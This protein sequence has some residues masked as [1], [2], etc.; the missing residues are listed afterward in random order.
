MFFLLPKDSILGDGYDFLPH[1]RL[2]PLLEALMQTATGSIT[3]LFQ[4]FQLA[5][6]PQYEQY[7]IQDL[8]ARQSWTSSLAFSF[9][10]SKT[11]L[12]WFPQAIRKFPQRGKTHLTLLAGCLA[13]PTILH[14]ERHFVNFK[15]YLWIGSKLRIGTKLNLTPILVPNL[16]I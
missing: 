14:Q 1:T 7:A 5:S 10:R 12:I 16:T 9:F 3:Y 15:S 4:A 8:E 2:F 11:C 6:T 13:A